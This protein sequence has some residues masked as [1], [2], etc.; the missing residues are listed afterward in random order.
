MAFKPITF[1]PGNPITATDL[2]NLQSNI[3]SV[4][5]QSEGLVS[6]SKDLTGQIKKVANRID[7]RSINIKGLSKDKI[8]DKEFNFRTN[9]TSTPF[10]VVSVGEDLKDKED[11]DI[12]AYALSPSTFKVMVKTN[13]STR[14]DIDINYI[15]VSIE[16]LPAS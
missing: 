9:F 5:K 7:A 8:V 3:E 6:T 2:N 10:V 1:S 13:D 15:A 14:K 12:S 11:I 4:Y 16:D